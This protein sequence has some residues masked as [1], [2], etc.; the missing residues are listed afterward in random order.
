[1][2]WKTWIPLILAAVLGLIAAKAGRDIVLRAQHSGVA[3]GRFTQIVVA[4]NDL[5]PGQALVAGDLALSATPIEHV[6]RSAFTSV[7]ELEG[8]VVVLP[9]VKGQSI[10]EAFL[11]PAG[12]GSGTQALIPSG[13]RAM[14][15]EVNEV[16]GVAGLLMPGCRVDVVTTLQ[17]EALNQSVARTLVENVKVLAVGQ[18]LTTGSQNEKEEAA[19]AKSATLLV[20]P[21]DVEAIELASRTGNTR[22]VLR[23][24]LDSQSTATGG[25]TVAELL[26]GQRKTSQVA[27]PVVVEAKPPA[28]AVAP[29]VAAQQGRAGHVVDVIRSGAV[30]RVEIPM[31]SIAAP[32]A[33]TG[34]DTKP[35]ED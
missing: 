31:E 22:L 6:P 11:A 14:T 35:P 21:R 12:S 27:A 1:M 33:L 23:G 19:R 25:V 26:G 29:P 8:R 3:P 2:N 10:V 7:S 24:T 13:M 16:S 4:K 15:I 20:S 9:V 30:S 17:D 28:K 5:Q 34:V 18:R 32:S